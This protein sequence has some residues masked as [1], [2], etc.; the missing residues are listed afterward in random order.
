MKLVK[1]SLN[2]LHLP[3]KS[4]E[5]IMNSLNFSNLSPDD[6]LSLSVKN[7]FIPGIDIA[8][9][10]GAD[11]NHITNIGYI[12][13]IWIDVINTTIEDENFEIFK[14]LVDKGA[15]ISDYHVYELISHDTINFLNYL[16]QTTPEI[17]ELLDRYNSGINDPE[18]SSEFTDDEFFYYLYDKIM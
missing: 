9:E 4:P 2:E 7:S 6:M 13:D 8:L 18:I 10:K 15:R 14:Y 11:I 16:E 17:K 1:E 5:D 12:D 3:G